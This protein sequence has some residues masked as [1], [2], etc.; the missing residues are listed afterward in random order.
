MI[1]IEYI[2]NKNMIEKS[3]KKLVSINVNR[4]SLF[5]ISVFSP[6]T[7]FVCI[8]LDI[9][10]ILIPLLIAILTLTQILRIIITKK[11]LN[12]NFERARIIYGYTDE[13]PETIVFEE[14]EWRVESEKRSA[15]LKYKDVLTYFVFDNQICITTKGNFLVN[16]PID[17]NSEQAKQ[18]EKLLVQ[19]GHATKIK[20][21]F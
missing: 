5:L 19:K 1:K 4:S 18:I 13:F 2:M 3:I 11:V 8:F 12:N 20:C 9:E 14:D 16:F 10:S 15:N 17:P 6:I 7:I 21:I